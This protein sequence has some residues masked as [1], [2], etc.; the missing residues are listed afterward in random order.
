MRF[1]ESSAYVQRQIDT[2]LRSHKE[3]SRIFIDDIVIYSKTL[4]DHIQ[5]LHTI[6]DL[7]RSRNISLSSI[8]IFLDYSSVQLLEQKIDAFDFITAVEK[9]EVIVRLQFSETFKDLEIYLE[10]TE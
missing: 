5:H 7:L 4:K 1:K 10:F 3:Y 6:F 2:I 9:I 8:K